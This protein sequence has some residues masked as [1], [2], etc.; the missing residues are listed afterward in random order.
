MLAR[1]VPIAH[2]GLTELTLIVDC[3]GLQGFG[4]TREVADLG[5]LSEKF[6]T[7][8][9]AVDEID[10]HCLESIAASMSSKVKG[11]RAIIA[12]TKKGC[13]ISFM[14]NRMEWHYLPMTSEQYQQALS[15]IGKP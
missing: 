7:F 11:P 14:E 1:R 5:S 6:R 4:S 12:H 3:N 2:H 10:G 8:G 9:F 15:E 13:G